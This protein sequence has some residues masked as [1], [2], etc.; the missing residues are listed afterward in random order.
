MAP[1]KVFN[2]KQMDQK[3]WDEYKAQ[4]HHNLLNSI[5][6]SELIE[7]YNNKYTRDTF[8]LEQKLASQYW[9]SQKYT[10]IQTAI[11]DVAY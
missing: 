5:K 9:I 6:I 4:T 8:T 2:W 7:Y 10:T 11:L 3:L 1:Q